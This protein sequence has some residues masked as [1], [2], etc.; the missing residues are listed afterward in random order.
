MKRNDWFEIGD[1]QRSAPKYPW[2]YEV[3]P[4]FPRGDIAMGDYDNPSGG[5][6]KKSVNFF[7]ITV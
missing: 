2:G 1:Y 4:D 5:S 6:L 3:S 7:G